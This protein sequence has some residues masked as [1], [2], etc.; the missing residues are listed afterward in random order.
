MDLAA[1]LYAQFGAKLVAGERK[2]PGCYFRPGMFLSDI[3]DGT[4]VKRCYFKDLI[5]LAK[6]FE[7]LHGLG[8][9]VGMGVQ[10]QLLQAKA[11]GPGEGTGFQ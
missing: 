8:T 7:G 1:G 6:G 4:I 10:P 3:L 11:A 9:D 2:V 5:P